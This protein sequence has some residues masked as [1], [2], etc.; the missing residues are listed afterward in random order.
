ML[1]NPTLNALVE[2]NL[3]G[4]H[5]ALLEQLNNS[6]HQALSFDERFGLLLDREAQDR[7]NRRL[8]RNLRAAKLRATACI[9][10]LDFRKQRGLDR[11]LVL[12]LADAHWVAAHETVIVTGP[13]GVGKTYVACALAQAAIRHGHTASYQR[14][15]RLLDELAISHADGRWPRLLMSLARVDVLILDDIGVRPLTGAQA[16]D[17]LEVIEDRTQRRATIITSQLPW[18]AWHDALGDPTV[19]DAI[20]DRLAH[21]CRRI[22][23]GGD[24]MRTTPQASLHRLSKADK[25]P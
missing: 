2:L 18:A 23:M 1:T 17:L 22:E 19:A 6:D 14:V 20:L 24:S 12:A 9:E 7:R 21:H 15:P 13:T 10:D 16:A 8:E 4:M 25:R 5:R 3:M 11:G